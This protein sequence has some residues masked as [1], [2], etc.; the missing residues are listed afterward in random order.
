MGMITSSPSEVHG[1]I[2]NT[3]ERGFGLETI[4]GVLR[5][6]Y[7]E[8]NLTVVHEWNPIRCFPEPQVVST[9]VKTASTEETTA[10]IIAALRDQDAEFIFTDFDQV[11]A[12]GH[13]QRAGGSSP[14]YVQAVENIDRAVGKVLEAISELGL[15]GRTHLILTADHG[16][17][18][19]GGDHT[20]CEFPVPFIVYGPRVQAGEISETVRNNQV[21]QVVA[22]L[23]T[24]PPSPA[25]SVGIEPFDRYIRR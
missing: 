7:P 11:D 12:A 1:V 15:E 20:P 25:W 24:A 2:S 10:A 13:H 3:C 6:T 14:G 9:F 23:F 17:Q 22:H 21:A 19:E 18:A 4:F 5:R 16:H 8:M